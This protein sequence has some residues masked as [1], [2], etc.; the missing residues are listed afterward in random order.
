MKNCLIGIIMIIALLFPSC[1]KQLTEEIGI[2][3]NTLT[4]KY[5]TLTANSKWIY[6]VK[7][8][9]ITPT[10][11]PTT[12]TITSSTKDT[13]INNNFY[14]IFINS[15]GGNQYLNIR[16]HDYYQY[17]SLPLPNAGAIERLYLKDDA[18]V[19]T[20]WIQNI[21]LNIPNVPIPLPLLITNTIKAKGISRTVNNI[22]YADVFHVQTTISSILIPA[23]S[24]T[25]DI[26]SYYA[27]KFGLIENTSVIKLN[28]TGIMQNA[29]IKTILLSADLK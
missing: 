12:F 15:N 26:N 9:N 27:K 13:T 2:I 16:G 7:N 24:F 6:Q 11:A 5:I 20:S 1:Q 28:Y 3:N 18:L 4:D 22:D 8:Y 14:H 29:D 10:T 21:N 25:T 17:D 23:A 19:N